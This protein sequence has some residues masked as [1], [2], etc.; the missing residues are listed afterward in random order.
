MPDIYQKKMHLKV[1]N[2]WWNEM[3]N[4]ADRTYW[5][6]LYDE[7]GK[8]S[9][10]GNGVLGENPTNRAEKVVLAAAG[11]RPFTDY[12]A[13]GNWWYLVGGPDFTKIE[14]PDGLAVNA[15]S[16]PFALFLYDR[17]NESSDGRGG[18]GGRGGNGGGASALAE[19]KLRANLKITDFAYADGQA[20]GAA[21]AT[22]VDMTTGQAIVDEVLRGTRLSVLATDSL[23]GG[24]WTEIGAPTTDGE[25][26]WTADEGAAA[27]QPAQRFFRLQLK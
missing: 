17:K 3:L 20:S 21:S 27:E 22:V 24:E 7:E 2:G 8:W 1:V 19:Y 16:W 10:D 11:E 9:V 12:T 13:S 4:G 18:R 26:V 14:K 15:G 23:E 5:V 25:G 6:T